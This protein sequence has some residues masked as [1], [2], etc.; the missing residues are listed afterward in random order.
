[1]AR[2]DT[3]SGI[4]SVGRLRRELRGGLGSCS[5]LGLLLRPP[6]PD[7]ALGRN[8]ALARQGIARFASQ[9]VLVLPLAGLVS[10]KVVIWTVS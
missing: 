9:G 3:V 5:S 2:L 6:T 7:L 4:A 8:D 1:M 10:E